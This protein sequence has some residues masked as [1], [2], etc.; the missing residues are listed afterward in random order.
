MSVTVSSYVTVFPLPHTSRLIIVA[1]EIS[2]VRGITC[3]RL[4]LIRARITRCI[5]LQVHTVHLTASPI[6]PPKMLGSEEVPP[7]AD[8][9]SNQSADPKSRGTNLPSPESSAFRSFF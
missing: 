5:H 2:G 1:N 6:K 4:L 8:F 9:E 3:Y 7:S